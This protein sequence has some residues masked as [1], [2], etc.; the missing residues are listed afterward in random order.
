MF[1]R[2]FLILIIIMIFAFSG[3]SV[4]QERKDDIDYSEFPSR[5]V[6]FSNIEGRLIK[7][8][9]Y[10]VQ[11]GTG[12]LAAE[13]RTIV[14]RGNE[15]PVK[16]IIEE[17]LNGPVDESLSRVSPEN[18][19]V[20]TVEVSVDI[21]NVYLR[22]HEL[23]EDK[24][25][26]LI[27]TA[28]ANTLIDYLNIKYVNI[29]INGRSEGL[30]QYP[31]P[32]QKN[33]SGIWTEN[34]DNQIGKFV[35]KDP[36]IENPENEVSVTTIEVPLYFF[37][38]S[39]EYILPEVRDI[40]FEDTN[41][42]EKIIEELNNGPRNG[43]VY[44]PSIN[45]EL[46]LLEEPGFLSDRGVEYML[47]NLSHSPSLSK[48]ENKE[49][50]LKSY[51]C[52]IYTLSSFFPNIDRIIVNVDGTKVSTIGG[53]VD[54]AQGIRR[55]DLS[56]YLADGIHL[57]FRIKDSNLL[58]KVNRMVSQESVWNADVRLFE[59]LKGPQS[60]EGTSSWPCFPSGVSDEDI[61]GTKTYRSTIIVDLSNNF[62]KMCQGLS[63]EQEMLLIFSMVNTLTDMQGINSVQFLV[64]GKGTEV[65]AGHLHFSDLFVK[66]PGL[67]QIDY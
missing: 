64:E 63:A 61:L 24:Q 30:S 58:M 31:S 3:C 29:F 49:D 66:N 35:A 43:Y 40:E 57:Y 1:K 12:K 11:K 14:V 4:I 42:I 33:T 48:F 59:L 52:L 50:E 25:R 5:V 28:V 9:L 15:N 46:S 17:L 62:K 38:A 41:Y 67:V 37:D 16:T 20:E 23:I 8:A 21:A 22:S 44:L 60:N 6:Q 55:R 47:L 53:S 27:K 65:L 19:F 34:Y 45:K 18:V 32:L 54:V 2:K 7:P 51:A 36:D 26:F 39:S 56:G 13:L 10:F